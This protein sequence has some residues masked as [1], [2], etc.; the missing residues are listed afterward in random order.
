MRIVF[1]I[2]CLLGMVSCGSSRSTSKRPD[3][4]GNWNWVST[5]GGFA[6]RTTTP[7]TS[8]S[9]RQLQIT[10]DS[11]YMYQ[12]GELTSV[13]A[14]QLTRAESQVQ[15]K[16]GWAFEVNDRRTFVVR[17][18]STLVLSEDCWDCFTHTYHRMPER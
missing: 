15:R 5:A 10:T 16:A 9:S 4:L 7:E 12:S 14:Y 2:A 11:I 18:D 13:S 3:I 8:H 6:G 1:V 17:R